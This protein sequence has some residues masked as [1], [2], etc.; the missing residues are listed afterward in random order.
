MDLAATLVARESLQAAEIRQRILHIRGQKPVFCHSYGSTLIVYCF[1]TAWLE[2]HNK[3]NGTDCEVISD[4]MG[5]Y[6]LVY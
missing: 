6:Y 2:V 1:L 5:K 4:V 3:Q